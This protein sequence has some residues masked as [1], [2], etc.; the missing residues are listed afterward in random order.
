MILAL[1]FPSVIYSS[2]DA[3]AR[4]VSKKVDATTLLAVQN[5]QAEMITVT[6]IFM[7]VFGVTIFL[8]SLFLSHRI[9]GP[10]YR[11]QSALDRW[12][13]GNVERNI[14]LRKFDHFEDLAATYNEAADQVFKLREQANISAE[15]LEKISEELEPKH[16]AQ[17]KELIGEL[18]CISKMK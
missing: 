14:T 4:I 9:A 7:I 17:L 11:V 16:K 8:I 5:F 15:K 2:I 6:T 13:R 3:F 1:V 10:V 18:Q 12:K